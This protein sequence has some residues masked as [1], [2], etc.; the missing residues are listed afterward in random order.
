MLVP[1]S[2]NEQTCSFVWHQ[3]LMILQCILRV[4]TIVVDNIGVEEEVIL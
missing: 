1:A 4:S 3:F 2:M